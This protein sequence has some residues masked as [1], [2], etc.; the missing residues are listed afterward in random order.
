MRCLAVS[1]LLVVVLLDQGAT[2]ERVNVPAELVDDVLRDFERDVRQLWE[3]RHGGREE[4]A[5]A[6]DMQVDGERLKPAV[7]VKHGSQEPDTRTATALSVTGIR[8]SSKL[9]EFIPVSTKYVPYVRMTRKMDMPWPSG[10]EEMFSPAERKSSPPSNGPQGYVRLQEVLTANGRLNGAHKS[11]EADQGS[12]MVLLV[13][14]Y[15]NLPTKQRRMVVRSH[16]LCLPCLVYLGS[17]VV[18]SRASPAL[19]ATL[20]CWKPRT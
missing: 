9:A 16:I 19:Y 5:N 18:R 13:Y 10:R 1:R 11:A 3:N 14:S 4:D 2:A 12:R 20:G 17:R 8:G 15:F 6:R 7:L